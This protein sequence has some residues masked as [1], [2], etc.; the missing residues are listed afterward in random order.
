MSPAG[1]VNGDGLRDLLIGDPEGGISRLF[2]LLGRT[3]D[4][5]WPTVEHLN[6]LTKSDVS[7]SAIG[8]IGMPRLGAAMTPMGDLDNDGLSDFAFG[9]PGTG[10]GPNRS[11]IVLA[12]NI[13]YTLDRPVVGGGL[14]PRRRV[15]TRN[16]RVSTSRVV[17]STATAFVTS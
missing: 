6:L 16:V 10:S 3:P 12:K 17:T 5:P 14:L 8:A 1:D 11:G 4:N 2:L 15:R 13:S 9:H 7:W